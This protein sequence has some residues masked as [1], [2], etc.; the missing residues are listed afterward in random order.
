[1]CGR[2]A[3]LHVAARPVA[4]MNRKSTGQRSFVLVAGIQRLDDAQHAF[5]RLRAR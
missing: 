4:L 1:M 5:V 3:R 2:S